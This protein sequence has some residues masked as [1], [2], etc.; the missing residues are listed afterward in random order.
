[1]S[2]LSF[3]LFTSIMFQ[4]W[5]ATTNTIRQL[6]TEVGDNVLLMEF[7]Q[8]WRWNVCHP[9]GR[10][11]GFLSQGKETPRYQTA[12]ILCFKET[13]NLEIIVEDATNN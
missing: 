1:M 7:I 4:Q 8:A 13:E 5:V 11:A 10:V 12:T 9:G 6:A 3:L 2:N